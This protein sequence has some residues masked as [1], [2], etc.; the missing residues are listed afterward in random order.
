MK[1]KIIAAVGDLFFAA[2]IRGTAE[3]VGAEAAFPKTADALLASA[4]EAKPALIVFD[5]Q[6]TNLDPFA[7]ARTLKA[8]ETLRDVPLLA[9]FSHVETELRTRAQESGF[10]AVMPRS[11]FAARLV[12]ILRGD[13]D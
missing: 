10:D 6:A 3:Q 5:L 2:K 12:E 4:R 7:L 11:Q 8:D 13:S 9:F 1:R